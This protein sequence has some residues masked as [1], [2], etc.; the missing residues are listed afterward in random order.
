MKGS[1]PVGAALPAKLSLG[2]GRG[3]GCGAVVSAAALLT[4]L[5]ELAVISVLRSAAGASAVALSA[6][7]AALLQPL[8][9][10]IRP[11]AS[12]KANDLML[13]VI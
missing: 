10:T 2:A 1:G 13:F 7:A 8:V 6:G 3:A 12:A 5:A 9:A 11:I 4:V